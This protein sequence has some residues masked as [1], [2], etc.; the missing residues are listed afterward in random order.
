MSAGDDCP[1]AKPRFFA[2]CVLIASGIEKGIDLSI[3]VLIY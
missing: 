3:W 2:G 1:P